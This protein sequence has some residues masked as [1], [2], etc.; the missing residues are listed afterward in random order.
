MTATGN[1]RPVGCVIGA[2]GAAVS[3]DTNGFARA[4]C[5]DSNPGV[6]RVRWLTNGAIPDRNQRNAENWGLSLHLPFASC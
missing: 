2:G 4:C 6:R 5:C 3:Y 1:C